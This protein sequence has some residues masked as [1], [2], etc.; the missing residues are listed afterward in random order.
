MKKELIGFIP[1]D[2]GT[3]CI[4]D[5]CYLIASDSSHNPLTNE[6][7]NKLITKLCDKK[8]VAKYRFT[9]GA[10]TNCIMAAGFGGDGEYP[11]YA[12]RN[13]YG[14]IKKLEIVFH[15]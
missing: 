7:W 1:V 11:I 4:V 10:K 6:E 9:K 15:D 13:E 2:S 3:V 14:V 8:G 5:P 12:H